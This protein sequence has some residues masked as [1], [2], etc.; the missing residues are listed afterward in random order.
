[1]SISKFAVTFAVLAGLA[2]GA[3]LYNLSHSNA[4]V[5]DEGH[6]GYMA[7]RILRGHELLL[8]GAPAHYGATT[9]YATAAAFSLFGVSVFSAR[10]VP[11]FASIAAVLILMV[12]LH[13]IE[14]L[15]G[16]VLGGLLAIS[17]PWMTAFSRITWEMG[18]NILFVTLLGYFAYQYIYSPRKI[19]ALVA[20]F[21]LGMASN[22]HLYIATQA[23]PLVAVFLTSKSSP[24]SKF[25]A[26]ALAFCGSLVALAPL[27]FASWQNGWDLFSGY[28]ATGGTSHPEYFTGIFAKAMGVVATL[29]GSV[30]RPG[31][32]MFIIALLWAIQ[33]AYRRDLFATYIVLATFVSIATL[34]LVAK[35]LYASIL[36][37]SWC[38]FV[39]QHVLR[40]QC[41]GTE[42][43]YLDILFPFPLV[44]IAWFIA[45]ITRKKIGWYLALLVIIV[46]PLAPSTFARISN[47]HYERMEYLADA[48]D[49]DI[50][51]DGC[52]VL[53][54]ALRDYKR[55]LVMAG[56]RTVIELADYSK[57]KY[58]CDGVFLVSAFVERHGAYLTL[59]DTV[60][61]Q[62]QPIWFIYKVTSMDVD[63]LTCPSLI[64]PPDNLKFSNLRGFIEDKEFTGRHICNGD[65]AGTWMVKPQREFLNTS[66]HVLIDCKPGSEPGWLEVSTDNGKTWN[67]TCNRGPYD[68]P[69]TRW[70][71]TKLDVTPQSPDAMQILVRGHQEEGW[72][73]ELRLCTDTP[74]NIEE[75]IQYHPLQSL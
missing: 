15:R 28:A 2:I 49:A 38:G 26:I 58:V 45:H 32:L 67:R 36:D 56:D 53:N 6:N 24:R 75:L 18:P 30:G 17:A 65:C 74:E 31:G 25:T 52:I 13:R 3:R 46:Y 22:G 4:F 33:K 14:G 54:S 51:V 62:Q 39:S 9:H 71:D 43:R 55:L 47:I 59:I 69:L 5:S 50:P 35:P 44:L 20:G 63:D 1:M 60:Y 21:C 61:M 16:M 7:L 12:W 41:V 27:L 68:R 10:L 29:M 70:I 48:I 11:A 57:D 37:Q 64:A 73:Q 40:E 66:L 19:Y 72:F 23:I 8:R 34:V 42:D